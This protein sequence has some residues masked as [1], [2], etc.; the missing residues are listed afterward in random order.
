MIHR[1]SSNNV[2]VRGLRRLARDRGYRHERRAFVVEGPGL[3]S[4]ALDAGL[5]VGMVVVPESALDDARVGSRL[6]SLLAQADVTGAD[7]GTVP[8]NIFDGLSSTGTPQPA[9]A[10]V[11][12]VDMDTDVM[13]A[14]VQPGCP[15]LVLVELADPGNV[16]TLLRSA[17]AFGAAGVLIVGGVDLYNPKVVR[18]AAGSAFRL[19]LATVGYESILEMLGR[20]SEAGIDT[21]ATVPLGGAKLGDVVAT[22]QQVAIVLGNEPHGLD[23]TVLAACNGTATVETA[24]GVDSLNVAVAGSVALYELRRSRNTD[25]S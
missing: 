10:E 2:R 25:N 7:V 6:E 12:F 22:D 19:P 5:D 3:V 11:G 15:L 8:D 9:L 4:D 20:L 23:A 21:W 17:E 24:G 18:A 1:Y 13:L 14:A 16:G